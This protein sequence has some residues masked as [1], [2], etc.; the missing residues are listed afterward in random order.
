MLEKKYM[1]IKYTIPSKNEAQ[2]PLRFNIII[3]EAQESP[4]R[5]AK[6]E[7]E[8]CWDILIIKASQKKESQ[9]L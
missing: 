8:I 1:V 2:N 3:A 4:K 6:P 7:S 5:F 9:A